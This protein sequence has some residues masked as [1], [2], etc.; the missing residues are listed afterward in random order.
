MRKLQIL[1]LSIMLM[2]VGCA[3]PVSK[4][5]DNQR[6]SLLNNGYPPHYVDGYIDGCGSYR[7]GT[8]G[9]MKDVD[10]SLHNDHYRSGWHDG[11]TTCKDENTR[12]KLEEIESNL[13]WGP[14]LIWY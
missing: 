5:L 13:M 12:K 6:I 8:K 1:S 11:Y 10:R 3:A 4:Q 7:Y 2:L 9:L 14:D